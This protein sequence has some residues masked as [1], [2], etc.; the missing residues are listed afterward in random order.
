MSSIVFR[1]MTLGQLAIWFFIYSFFGWAMEC[2]VIRIQ[3]K[4]W[5]NRGFAKLPFCV[6]YGFGVLIAFTI[7]KPIEHNF[8]AL[9]AFGSV[10]A[11][12]FEFMTAQLM[13]KLFGEVW[14]NY[15]H[16]PFNY[17]GILCLESTIG[18][19][20]IAVLV[21]G[22]INPVLESLVLLINPEIASIVGGV[23]TGAY[24]IDFAINFTKKLNLNLT[25]PN[26]LKKL[27]TVSFSGIPKIDGQQIEALMARIRKR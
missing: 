2:V 25:S 16:L 27:P 1:D 11:T 19:G 6:I 18:W 17:K 5:E 10:C 23:L 13:L 3:L 4:H 24:L 14:W 9:F 15:D 7:F 22:F 12:A 20:V 21:F 8:L 26:F